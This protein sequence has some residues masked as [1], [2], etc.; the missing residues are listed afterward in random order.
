[1][2]G[3]NQG[4]SRTSLLVGAPGEFIWYF[5]IHYGTIVL[6]KSLPRRGCEKETQ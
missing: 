5:H 6:T 2:S 1:M 3:R 4:V